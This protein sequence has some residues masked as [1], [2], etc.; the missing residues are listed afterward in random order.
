MLF[1]ND[2]CPKWA[3]NSRK[4]RFLLKIKFVDRIDLFKQK[5]SIK[6]N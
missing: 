4:K 6:Y 3:K 5:Q 2:K 1:I